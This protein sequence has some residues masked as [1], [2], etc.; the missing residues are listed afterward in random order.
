MNNAIDT[1][2]YCFQMVVSV[3]P[4]KSFHSSGGMGP[5]SSRLEQIS[6]SIAPSCVHETDHGHPPSCCTLSSTTTTS[7]TTSPF[8]LLRTASSTHPIFDPTIASP[9][10][11]QF[12]VTTI[13]CAYC[14]LRSSRHPTK[15]GG[16]LNHICSSSSSRRTNDRVFYHVANR[17][18]NPTHCTRLI[19]R[20]KLILWR[21]GNYGVP[22]LAR[23]RQHHLKSR[24]ALPSSWQLEAYYTPPVQNRLH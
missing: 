3:A 19:R 12:I 20:T 9:H 4:S 11:C 13:I 8:N 5:L 22:R 1:A 10:I 14:Q 2:G 23:P 6:F 16:P 18:L 7:H 17:D 24:H 21:Q 15:I